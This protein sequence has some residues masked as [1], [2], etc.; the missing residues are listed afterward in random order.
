MQLEEVGNDGFVAEEYHAP[1]IWQGGMFVALEMHNLDAEE[2]ADG[3]CP[4][5][6]EMA[7]AHAV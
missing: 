4:R 6:V 1:E 3:R 5:V 2:M 7:Y